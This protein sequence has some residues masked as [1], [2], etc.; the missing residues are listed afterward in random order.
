MRRRIMTA[1]LIGVGLTILGCAKRS[2]HRGMGAGAD[3]AGLRDTS[4]TAPKP[5]DTTKVPQ[6]Y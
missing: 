2:G 4:Q 6:K 3:T 1:V 5:A